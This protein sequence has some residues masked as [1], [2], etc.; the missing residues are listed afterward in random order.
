MA[1][2]WLVGW[3]RNKHIILYYKN[4]RFFLFTSTEK[5]GFSKEENSHYKT[6]WFQVK[7]GCK[8]TRDHCVLSQ[9]LGYSA[10][11]HYKNIRTALPVFDFVDF[12]STNMK[13]LPRLLNYISASTIQSQKIQ[14][15]TDDTLTPANF[16][17]I[18]PSYWKLRYELVNIN[19]CTSISWNYETVHG[20]SC[21]KMRHVTRSI[22]NS[23]DHRLNLVSTNQRSSPKFPTFKIFS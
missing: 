8:I 1:D 20:F 23:P 10:H 16:F 3:L 5:S 18:I 12:L 14:P 22:G 13:S 9:T 4:F 15:T 19:I 21:L 7:M 2:G 6:H 17:N 11:L